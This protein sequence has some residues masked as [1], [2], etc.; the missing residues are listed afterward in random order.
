MKIW[1]YSTDTTPPLG[2]L[3]NW[4]VKPLQ[5]LGHEVTLS[6]TLPKIKV[7]LLLTDLNTTRTPIDVIGD[8]V[9]VIFLWDEP[10]GGGYNMKEHFDL[11]CSNYYIPSDKFAVIEYACPTWEYYPMDVKKEIDVCF[12]G[13]LKNDRETWIKEISA[14]WLG[15]RDINDQII[16]VNHLRQLYNRSR[17]TFNTQ[18]G[19]DTP[20]FKGYGLSCR[21]FEALGCK[22]PIIQDERLYLNAYFKPGKEIIVYDGELKTL[23]KE[24]AYWLENEK[25]RKAIAEAGY[26]RIIKE[27]TYH[28]RAKQLMKELEDRGLI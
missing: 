18:T 12:I 6:R 10:R 11:V 22:C 2:V 8:P 23:K 9:K 15:R 3:G 19:Q 21:P 28:H 1:I 14:F 4:W 5:D 24:I 20:P 16:D 17:I 25:E 27:H 26:N 13:H 7:D